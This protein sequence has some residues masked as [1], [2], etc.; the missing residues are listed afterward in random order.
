VVITT[1]TPTVT[2]KVVNWVLIA[3][4]TSTNNRPVISL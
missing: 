3:P 1:P 2:G 4:N